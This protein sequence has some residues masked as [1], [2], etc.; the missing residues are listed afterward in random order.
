MSF[1]EEG[2]ARKELE[3]NMSLCVFAAKVEEKQAAIEVNR[4]FSLIVTFLGNKSKNAIL[5]HEGTRQA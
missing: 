5:C 4:Q 1:S 2:E 3:L